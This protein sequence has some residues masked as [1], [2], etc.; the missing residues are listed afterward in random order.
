VSSTTDSEHASHH[1]ITA[2]V[3]R[4]TYSVEEA[5]RILGIGRNSAYEAV[6]EGTIPALRIG[7]RIVIPKAALDRMLA[8][9]GS[10]AV[11]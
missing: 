9:E 4:R 3:E 5:G 2:D 7:K 11:A 6:R 1:E 8:G 10:D